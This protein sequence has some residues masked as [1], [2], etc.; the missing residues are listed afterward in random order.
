M[1]NDQ[2]F[3]GGGVVV[4][5]SGDNF[6]AQTGTN[7]PVSYT[8]LFSQPYGSVSWVRTELPAANVGASLP[9]WRAHIFD[10]MG[11][12]L[13]SAGENALGAYTNIPAAR[14]TLLG[15]GT[16]PNISSIRFDGNNQGISSLSTLTLDDLLLSTTPTNTTL[17]V[18]LANQAGTALAAPGAV[19]LGAAVSDSGGTVSQVNFYEGSNFISSAAVSQG[20]AALTLNHLAAGNYVFTAE[21]SDSTGAVVASTPLTN[22]VTPATG[23]S[24]INF[25]VLNTSAG[26]VGGTALS[27]YLS[28]NFGVT[29]SN[30]TVGT[31]MEAV[32]GGLVAGSGGA[33]ASSPPNYFTQAGLNQPVSFTLRFRSPLQAFGFTR[34]ALLAGAGGVSH[35]QWTATVFDANGTQ[36]GSAGENLITSASNVPARSFILTGLNGDGI[37]SARFDS[38][39]RQTAAF[40]AVLLDDLILNA[41]NAGAVTP[42]LSVSLITSLPANGVSQA[43]VTDTLTASV[44]DNLGAGNSASTNYSISFYAGPNLLG[45]VGYPANSFAINNVL[46]GTY[47]LRAQ[48]VDSSGVTAY[49]GPVTNTVA[50]TGGNSQV[51][52][53]DSAVLNATKGPVS[54]AVLSNYLATN[55]I[56]VTTN[57]TTGTV[58]A[59]ENQAAINGGGAVAA[60]SP[61]NIL[62]QLGTGGPVSYTLKFA[63]PLTNIGFTRPELLANPFVSQPAWQATAFDAVGVALGS[64]GEGL[65]GSYTNVGAQAFTLSGPGIA[66]VQFASQGSG[67]TTFNAMVADDFVLTTNAA[68]VSFP[69]AVAIT[70]PPAGLQVVSP[71]ALTVTAQAVDPAG[72]KSVSFYANGALIGSATSSPYSAQWTNGTQANLGA[73]AYALTAVALDNNN[74]SRTSPV[75]NVTIL[76]TEFVFAIVTPPASQT[77]KMGSSVTLSVA[78]TGTGSVAYQWYQNG[79]MLAGQ[80]ESTL[81][82][83]PL[84][85][86][87]A[88]SYTVTATSGGLTL[89]SAPPAVVT[90]AQPPVITTQPL[91]Q[92]NTIGANVVLSVTASGDGPFSYQWLRNGANIPGATNSTYSILAA[93]PLNSGICQVCGRQLSG[94]CGERA[95]G[96]GGAVRQQ[97]GSNRQQRHLRQPAPHQP[98]AGA[99]AGQ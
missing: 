7:G 86:T 10:S 2:V 77:A 91:G 54:G 75:V 57:I 53:F 48:V 27:N 5:S 33:V 82:L 64:T 93:Q 31:A 39:S 32:N 41:T 84:N 94:L 66:S 88:G 58:L 9:G 56:L 4:A 43:P 17:A 11:N 65:I 47:V 29:L 38:D 28:T 78:T 1:A 99:G 16:A 26:S 92:T 68:G 35:P 71:A 89:T 61:P 46:A 3:L 87:N 51:V 59:V 72:I 22:T 80:T 14:F 83:F 45:T 44:T 40:S 96:G 98:A 90:V 79:T 50:V 20:A 69:P 81:T 12:E 74:L 8:L 85:S 13:G 23:V 62:T 95:G 63:A 97:P 6:L 42:L 73:G 37:A 36:L 21:A 24:V 76:P 34:V 49:S 15:N 60:S 25:D 19:V 30:V 67:L 55:G 52:N 70:A 18:S